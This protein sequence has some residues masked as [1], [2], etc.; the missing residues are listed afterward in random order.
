M[1]VRIYYEDTDSG[2]IVYHANYLKY[3]ERARTEFLRQ[4]GISVKELHDKGVIFPV[5]RVE[6]DFKA[7]AVHDD[8]IKVETKVL[9]LGR[10]TFSVAQQIIRVSDRKLLVAATVTLASVGHDIR[11]KRLPEDI[12]AVLKQDLP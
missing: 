9:K 7:P 5:T 8:N 10:A 11:P 6:V 2:G 3:L 4:R 12:V 1:E